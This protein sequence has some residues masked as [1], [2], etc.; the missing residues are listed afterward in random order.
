LGL[1]HWPLVALVICTL[2]C[3]KGQN[4]P[5]TRPTIEP[6]PAIAKSPKIA[7]LVPA[8]TDLIIA[9]GA[10]D[11]L[12]AISSWD[13][14]RADVSGLPVGGDYDGPDWEKIS[15]LRPSIMIVFM[16]IDRM[17]GGIK[18]RADELGIQLVNVKTE[19][20]A[21]IFQTIDDLGKL[22][23]EPQKASQL[24]RKMH[25][26]L[27]AVAQRVAGKE[28]IPTLLARD[29][30]GFALIAGDT[31]ADDLLTLAGGKN[32][33]GDFQMRYPTVDAE[34]VLQLSPRV[35][36]QL[37]PNASPQVVQQSM[38]MWNKL[39]SLP[40]VRDKHVYVLT[41]WYVL[42]PGSHIA[43]LAEQFAQKLHPQ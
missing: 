38:T 21:D 22:L 4:V 43:E 9:M 31:F 35:V 12:V 5:T 34:R 6:A 18:Q 7:S 8:A 25:S 33:A 30:A 42:Q 41:D 32:V 29:D 39:D 20:V 26:Q 40:A 17:P 1:G 2:G 37:M 27:D 23:N 24:S 15:Q 11:H 16:A 14:D 28:K 10:S 3:E 13:K 36:F 19:R